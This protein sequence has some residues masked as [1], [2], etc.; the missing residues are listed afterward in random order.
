MT[1]QVVV[2]IDLCK[3]KLFSQERE[4]EDPEIRK[5]LAE[6]LKEIALEQFPYSE[7]KY[8]EGSFYKTEG[9]A[10]YFILEKPT[11]AIRSAIEFMKEWFYRGIKQ[12]FPESKIIIHRG[13][14]DTISVPEGKDFVGKVF[15]DISVVEKTLDEGNIYVTEHVR[16]NADLTISKF[17]NY[18]RRKV[19]T[20]ESITIYCVAFCDPRTFENDALAHL[21][22]IAHKESA[23]TRN[24]I[25]RFFLVEYLMENA[26][27][28]EL[29][30]FENWSRSKGYSYLP[31]DEIRQ[32]LS[33]RTL[34][35][36]ES[37]GNISTYKLRE[38]RILEIKKEQEGY[39]GAVDQAVK[40]VCDEIIKDTGTEKAIDGF[41]VKKIMDE[42]LC[43]LFSEIRMMA[44]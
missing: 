43:G 31:R 7:K 18:G 20:N 39:K 33:D 36:L 42:Y 17:V 40:T 28:S 5:V 26:Q 32:L 1:P 8:P 13:R 10:V 41:D 14:I 19:S 16:K 23:E 25:F 44:N 22:F 34:F 12:S 15:E 6:K 37:I 29:D 2:K 24:K 35:E 11:V 38:E 4:T 21:L 9:D 30:K 3:S 27:L